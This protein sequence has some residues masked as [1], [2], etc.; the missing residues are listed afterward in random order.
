MR[1]L[2]DVKGKDFAQVLDADKLN[3]LLQ[4]VPRSTA[5]ELVRRSREQID[6]VLDRAEQAVA[7]LRAE[8]VEAARAR[9]SEEIGRETER[10]QELA[11]VNPNIR[12]EEIDYLNERLARSL[13]YLDQASL[14]LDAVRVIVAV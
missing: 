4:K 6:G 8:Q 11:K 1:V 10:L 9:V 12:Q 2:M 14:K 13:E 5:Q 7:P 3:R